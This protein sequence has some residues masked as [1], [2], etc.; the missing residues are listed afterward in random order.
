MNIE[1]RPNTWEEFPT[2]KRVNARA[3]NNFYDDSDIERFAVIFEPERSLC[4]LDEGQIVGCT[5]SYSLEMMVPGGVVPIGAVAQVSVQATHRRRGINTML[6]KR[7]L[8]DIYE[9]GD[10]IAVLQAS[11]SIIYGRYGYGM[12]SFEY[13]FELER[14]HG[15]FSRRYEPEGRLLFIE[16]DEARK[17]F[18]QVFERATLLRNGMVKRDDKWWKFRFAQTGLRGGDPRAWF[19]KYQVDGRVDGYVWFTIRDAHLMT[20]IELMSATDDA[21]AALWQFCFDMDLVTTVTASR[22]AADEPLPWLMADPRR[23]TQSFQDASW[24]RLV[25]VLAAL[26]ARRYSTTDSLTLGV[27]DPFLEWNDC[28]V[29]LDV[30]PDESYCRTTDAEPD[31]TLSAADLGAVYLGGVKLRTLHHAGRVEENT[32]GALARADAMFATDLKPWC[33]DSW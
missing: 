20:V 17:V 3:Q 29:R 25:D 30:A 19:V 23:L 14:P 33:I 31:L 11:E 18:P 10:P 13:S 6:M 26:S 5:T 4:A 32:P 28:T 1:I 16:E 7:Q 8:T 9:R 27:S 21:Y 2:L 12:A 24:L 15:A 22:R